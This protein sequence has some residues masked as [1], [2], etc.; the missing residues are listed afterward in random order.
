MSLSGM[1]PQMEEFIF[2]TPLKINSIVFISKTLGDDIKQ[3][4]DD[5]A[6]LLS[7]GS[8]I[9]VAM[10]DAVD[11]NLLKTLPH[12]AVI[13]WPDMSKYDPELLR[14]EILGNLACSQN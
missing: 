11:I 13:S 6:T 5:A 7:R 12:T 4:H 10:G 9:F 1:L 8:L 3:S 2:D 14:Q